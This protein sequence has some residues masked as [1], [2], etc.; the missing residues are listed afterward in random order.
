MIELLIS[1]AP[2]NIE[3]MLDADQL[4]DNDATEN[5]E[6][7]GTNV[8][9]NILKMLYARALSQSLLRESEVSLMVI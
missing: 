5:P 2:S 9:L 6:N 7:R 4:V 8:F 1:L 3:D